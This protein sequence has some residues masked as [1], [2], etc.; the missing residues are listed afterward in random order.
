M[1]NVDTVILCTKGSNAVVLSGVTVIAE[2][3]EAAMMA[4]WLSRIARFVSK[5]VK[6]LF[7]WPRLDIDTFLSSTCSLIFVCLGIIS[8]FTRVST[9]SVV[10]SPLPAL[11]ALM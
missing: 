2:E 11:R 10:F 8:A 6:S 1:A 3:E 7:T 5:V 4:S 9:I